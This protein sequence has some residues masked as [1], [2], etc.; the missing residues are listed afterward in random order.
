AA[1]SRDQFL[2]TTVTGVLR[3]RSQPAGRELLA[4]QLG[5][6][7]IILGWSGSSNI[8]LSGTLRRPSGMPGNIGFQL[9]EPLRFFST[10]EPCRYS[11][12]SIVSRRTDRSLLVWIALQCCWL[13]ATPSAKRRKSVV[14]RGRRS[15]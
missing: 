8:G 13:C 4:R 15:G 11:M 7:E 3:D 2:A 9:S 12:M 1:R 14:G 6:R 5:V 10:Q